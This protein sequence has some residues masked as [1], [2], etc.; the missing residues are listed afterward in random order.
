MTQEG[1][2]FTVKD[3]KRKYTNLVGGQL[4]T[5]ADG[6]LFNIKSDKKSELYKICKKDEELDI[7]LDSVE[8]F[9]L[10]SIC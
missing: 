2:K 3:C 1:D 9:R 5:S 6:S 10:P 8:A 7:S 4:H